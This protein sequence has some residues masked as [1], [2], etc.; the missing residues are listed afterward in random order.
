MGLPPNGWFIREN[1]KQQCMIT[2]GT[3]YF[4]GNPQMDKPPVRCINILAS[5]GLCQVSLQTQEPA[6]T[7]SR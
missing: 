1:P 2:G 7:G 3:P 6:E 5:P 4:S